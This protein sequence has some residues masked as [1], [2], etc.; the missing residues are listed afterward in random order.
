M[1]EINAMKCRVYFGLLMF[2]FWSTPITAQDQSLDQS[3]AERRIARAQ[4]TT[5]IVDREPVDRVLVLSPPVEEVYFFTD[6]RHMEGDTA[7]HSW[8]YR[9]ELVSRV[10]FEVGGARWR[11]YS[12][13]RLEPNQLGEWSVTVTDGN[14]WPLYTEL[15]RY[16]PAQ[17]GAAQPLE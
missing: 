16:Q 3:T 5:D 6:L 14:G 12:K 11:V 1:K 13:M 9:G 10:S 15:F 4:F 8:R 17:P 2:S 7:V